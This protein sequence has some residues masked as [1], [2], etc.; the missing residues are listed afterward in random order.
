MGDIEKI[1][2]ER[3]GSHNNSLLANIVTQW[4]LYFNLVEVLISAVI[5]VSYA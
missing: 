4:V 1:L 3:P 2:A 5:Y